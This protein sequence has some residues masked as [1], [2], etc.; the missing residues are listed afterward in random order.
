MR[1]RLSARQ[2]ELAQ[3]QAFMF[4]KA[5]QDQC[6]FEFLFRPSLGDK[7]L[8]DPLWKMPEKG[9]F[10]EDF[11]NDLLQGNTDLVV[12][13]WKDLPIESKTKTQIVATL[14]RADPRDLLVFKKTSLRKKN[15]RIFS[16]SP[17]RAYHLAENL[18][19]L[20]PFAV[21]GLSFLPVRGNIQTRFRKLAED[22][23]I[24]GLIVAKAAVDRLIEQNEFP[25]TK[26]QIQQYLNQLEWMVLPSDLCPPAAAQGA[27]AVE[28]ASENQSVLNRVA[29]VNDSQTF[30]CV[31]M[32][33]ALLK[34]FGG[35]C[36]QKIGV[37]VLKLQDQ[38]LVSLSGQ[39]ESG[40][41]LKYRKLVKTFD[42]KAIQNQAQKSNSGLKQS[43]VFTSKELGRFT[44]RIPLAVTVDPDRHYLVSKAD[45]LPAAVRTQ[46]LLWVAG[47]ETWKKLAQRGLWVH[48]SLEGLGEAF[49]PSAISWADSKLDWKKLTHTEAVNSANSVA[50][51]QL[52]LTKGW[53]EHFKSRL[54]E[55]RHFYWTSGF[56]FKQA[57]NEFPQ[58]KEKAHGCGPGNTLEV[59]QSFGID[60]MVCLNSE[61]MN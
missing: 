26:V 22:S 1:L 5:L 28:V 11:V 8:T 24:D 47:S 39:T 60:P 10:T 56:Y 15:I 29:A 51:Y 16:S 49:L 25:Q 44:E 4:A 40:V 17:R 58:I 45:A 19:E 48:G 18:K 33:R 57:L 59:L 13:S 35:G 7:N 23:E 61:D 52:Q 31:E 32:E 41:T 27:I 2:S 20:L 43:N 30:E 55:C 37:L 6:E 14:K 3:V 53:R 36:H 34:S 42:L 50:T 12:H 9:V 21:D 46:K 54:N 38:F